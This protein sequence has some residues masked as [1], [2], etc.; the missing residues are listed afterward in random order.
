MYNKPIGLSTKGLRPYFLYHGQQKGV[1]PSEKG[2]QAVI[3]AIL[4]LP[5]HQQTLA[6]VPIDSF[7]FN[8]TLFE[9]TRT[10]EKNPTFH[11]AA[12]AFELSRCID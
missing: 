7:I 9:N 12:I 8:F 2:I 10:F 4:M 6:L 3:K 1:K 11:Q 5:K